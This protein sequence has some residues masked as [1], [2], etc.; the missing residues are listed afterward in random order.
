SAI[1]RHQLYAEV[2]TLQGKLERKTKA[3]R[4]L[5]QKVRGWRDHF[6]R[7]QAATSRLQTALDASIPSIPGDDPMYP[8]LREIN[9]RAREVS[10]QVAN[11][12][13]FVYSTADAVDRSSGAGGARKEVEEA[14]AK[15]GIRKEDVAGFAS[16]AHHTAKAA[17]AEEQKQV[18]AW[19][20]PPG[21]HEVP[22]ELEYLKAIALAAKAAAAARQALIASQFGDAANS[23]G[24]FSTRAGFSPVTGQAASR[25]AAHAFG[26]ST[27]A[28]DLSSAV[29]P[30]VERRA[31]AM[32]QARERAA[33]AAGQEHVVDH[34]AQNAAV[35]RFGV[36]EVT[37]QGRAEMAAAAH[38]AAKDLTDMQRLQQI[39]SYY[40]SFGARLE[41]HPQLKAPQYLRLLRDARALDSRVTS[42]EVDILFVRAAKA[43]VDA[44]RAAGAPA[45]S[46]SGGVVTTSTRLSFQG[47]V[48]VLMMTATLKFSRGMDAQVASHRSRTALIDQVPAAEQQE[49]L[50]RLLRDNI[51]PVHKDLLRDPV[52]AQDILGVGV[53]EFKKAFE[54]EFLAEEVVAWFKTHKGAMESMFYRYSMGS[55]AA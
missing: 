6:A 27:A 43:Q 21:A 2:E 24:H 20:H 28:R 30:S 54:K 48:M 46:P 34:S 36:G 12:G 13:P 38:A 10:E 40:A 51:L 22:P 16:R 18:S 49:A 35:R 19:A 5:G 26:T 3:H 52:F 50:A 15:R 47:F 14:L 23:G 4:A 45:G 7:L 32:K 17:Q 44:E 37:V 39:F 29:S 55:T 25:E 8:L 41:E 9:S 11:L 31:R 1:A 33:A 42:S 53:S